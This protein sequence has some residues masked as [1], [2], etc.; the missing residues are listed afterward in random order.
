MKSA[1]ALQDRLGEC[2]DGVVASQMLLRLGATAGVRPGE[3]GF[4]YGLLYA[5]LR[6]QRK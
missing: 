1:T 5:R 2:Q 6:Q 3:N 4:T